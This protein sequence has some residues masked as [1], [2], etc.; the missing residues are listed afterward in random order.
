MT[1]WYVAAIHMVMIYSQLKAIQIII[2]QV[3]TVQSLILAVIKFLCSFPGIL[4]WYHH[5]ASKPTASKEIV[6]YS[7]Y[8]SIEH[9]ASLMQADFSPL[10]LFAEAVWEWVWWEQSY[11]A[12]IEPRRLRVFI[13]WK[14]VLH[15]TLTVCLQWQGGAA[16]G[17][18]IWSRRWEA[19]HVHGHWW[20]DKVQSDQGDICGYI[21]YFKYA[22]PLKLDTFNNA[23]F[24]LYY[25]NHMQFSRSLRTH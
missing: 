4:W 9:L 2:L 7:H 8:P 6:S 10:I 21:S 3:H 25:N 17:L 1:A 24:C 12:I 15:L 22:I 16:L 23:C 14:R 5:S 18:G 13:T 19:W 20:G 11:K